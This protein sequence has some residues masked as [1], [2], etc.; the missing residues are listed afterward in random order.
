VRNLLWE[1]GCVRDLDHATVARSP[2]FLK[3]LLARTRHPADRTIPPAGSLQSLAMPKVVAAVWSQHI[4]ALIPNSMVPRYIRRVMQ[5]SCLD[6]RGSLP[7]R[8]PASRSF[9]AATV[10]SA[11]RP[12]GARCTPTIGTLRPPLSTTTPILGQ[13]SYLASSNRSI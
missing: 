6:H 4:I 8:I 3:N 1:P 2:A 12:S 11:N 9:S 5:G 13:G 7:S 10:F